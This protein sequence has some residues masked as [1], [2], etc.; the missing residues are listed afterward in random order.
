MS[1]CKM[2]KHNT[3]EAILISAMVFCALYFELELLGLI[4]LALITIL[5]LLSWV[6]VSNSIRDESN[7]LEFQRMRLENTKLELQI[8]KLKKEL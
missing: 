7:T 2:T 3:G 8:Q 4:A 1:G 6:T 5:P